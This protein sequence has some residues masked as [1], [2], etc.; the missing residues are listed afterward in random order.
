MPHEHNRSRHTCLVHLLDAIFVHFDG[1]ISHRAHLD[2][3][4]GDLQAFRCVAGLLLFGCGLAGTGF[5]LLLGFGLLLAEVALLQE[6][7]LGVVLLLLLFSIRGVVGGLSDSSL[8]LL[9][10]QALCLTPEPVNHRMGRHRVLGIVGKHERHQLLWQV[11]RVLVKE[12]AARLAFGWERV[13]SLL[14]FSFDFLLGL[15]DL[16]GLFGLS[17]H[18]KEIWELFF[19][20]CLRVPLS[21]STG[22]ER[23]CK[24][25]VCGSRTG[26]LLLRRILRL[27]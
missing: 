12:E 2:S 1:D 9:V 6:V 8:L 20:L 16:F 13:E 15:G 5:A 17:R 24:N 10:L 23:G 21:D 26:C 3:G 25:V 11:V 18:G 27:R 4:L 19:L 22:V 14:L 7:I